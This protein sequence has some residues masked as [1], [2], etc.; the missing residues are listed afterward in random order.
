MSSK[1]AKFYYTKNMVGFGKNLKRLRTERE[2]TQPQLARAVGVSNGTVSF[3]ETDKCEPTL[4]NI[5]NL[6]KVLGVSADELLG[7]V[8]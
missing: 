2:M 4:G 7:M 5:V 1:I 8:E 6:C 3:W